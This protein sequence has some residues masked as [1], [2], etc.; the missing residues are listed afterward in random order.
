MASKKAVDLVA[1]LLRQMY[2]PIDEDDP[3]SESEDDVREDA[4]VIVNALDALRRKTIEEARKEAVDEFKS[5]LPLYVAVGVLSFREKGPDVFVLG[6]F[7]SEANARAAGP[8]L[9]YGPHG[10]SGQW[11]VGMWVP[12]GRFAWDALEEEPEDPVA[13][14]KAQAREAEPGRW[15]AEYWESRRAEHDD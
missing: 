3:E 1:D 10:G 5:Q 6:P 7:R 8:S 13:W 12:D 9:A 11:R 15:S 2:V 4:T 14:I